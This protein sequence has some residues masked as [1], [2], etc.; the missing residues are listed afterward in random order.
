MIEIVTLMLLTAPVLEPVP[1][2]AVQYVDFLRHE[3]VFVAW[4][5]RTRSRRPLTEFVE[6]NTQPKRD[7]QRAF[8][9]R[10]KVRQW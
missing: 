1:V 3:P 4:W 6:D 8:E 7:R 5:T 9:F 2:E 10:K